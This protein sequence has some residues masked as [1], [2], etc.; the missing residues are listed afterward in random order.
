GAVMELDAA[1]VAVRLRTQHGI[2]R[3]VEDQA[4]FQ[5]LERGP[6]PHSAPGLFGMSTI[7][8]GARAE[9]LDE[10]RHEYSLLRC[11]MDEQTGE[12]PMLT[13]R[14][15]PAARQQALSSTRGGRPPLLRSPPAA[16]GSGCRSCRRARNQTVRRVSA[17]A[18]QGREP[19]WKR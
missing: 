17:S 13:G 8:P 14:L 6:D 3:D 2:K 11:S 7:C 4:V 18:C 16:D 10:L 19:P 15:T 9:P 1:V 12:R 5:A